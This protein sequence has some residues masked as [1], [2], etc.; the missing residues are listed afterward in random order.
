M[1]CRIENGVVYTHAYNAENRASNI[2]KRNTDRT[3][4]I[5]ESWSFA[6]DGDGNR[7]SI[8]HFIRTQG[9]PDSVTSYFMGGQYEVK[10]GATKKYYSI[11]GMT[12]AMQDGSAVQYLLTDHLGST[13][14]VANSSGTL[15]SQQRYLPFGGVRSIPNSPILAT[16]FGYTGQRL[17]DAGMGGIMDYKARF[18]S[19]ALGRFIQPDTI[20]PDQFNPQSWNRNSYVT[21]NPIRFNDPTGHCPNIIDC[22]I[23]ITKV[24]AFLTKRAIQNGGL[25]D[26]DFRNAADYAAPAVASGSKESISLSYGAFATWVKSKTLITTS[27]GEIQIFNESTATT[28]DIPH[29]GGLPGVTL[30]LTHG[31]VYNLEKAIDYKGSA[32]Q[33]NAGIPLLEVGGIT[34]EAYVSDN[35]KNHKATGK[36]PVWGL[37]VGPYVGIGPTIISGAHLIAK[38]TDNANGKIPTQLNGKGLLVCR[39]L[40]MCGAR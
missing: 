18:Y 12:V 39:L 28:N 15:T 31:A 8:A 17:L 16:D 37:D 1:T 34:G 5:I 40:S 26:T 10:D 20:I 30:S 7:V 38:P 27:K 32:V 23:E 25:S 6:Y 13:V 9:T 24:A 29:G 35:Y 4:T 33:L 21:N 3:G 22:V 14:A 36:S 19:P 2:A 11:A